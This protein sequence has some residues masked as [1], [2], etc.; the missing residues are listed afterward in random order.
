M[1]YRNF[2]ATDLKTS[3]LGI[4]CARIGSF[5]AKGDKKEIF[6][7]F[8]EAVDSGINFFDTSDIYGQGDSERFLGKALHGKRDKVIFE[9]KAGNCF[10]QTAKIA[11]RFKAPI[12]AALK[13]FPFLK[14]GIQQVRAAQL[15][16]NFAPSYLASAI[17]ASLRRLQTD[18]IDIF[19]LHSP[20][21]DVIERGEFL[22]LI[23]RLKTAGKI[24]YFGISC[25]TGDQALLC[26]KNSSIDAIQVPVNNKERFILESVLP[27]ANSQKVGVVARSPFS[28]GTLLKNANSGQTS[29]EAKSRLT[30]AQNALLSAAHYEGVSVVL[31]GMSNRQHLRENLFPFIK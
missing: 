25:D 13:H 18:Y 5:H 31:A 8:H 24:R 30:V 27:L 19:M 2:G 3:I 22:E 16:Q 4:G 7:M 1:E 9:T 23:Y 28:T 15:S 10:S 14:K 20:P 29:N 17:D 21:T 6:A 26:L 11:S 12:R